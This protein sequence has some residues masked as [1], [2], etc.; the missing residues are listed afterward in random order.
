MVILNLING[1]AITDIQVRVNTS[2]YKYLI[3][4]IFLETKT[5]C[6]IFNFQKENNILH[7]LRKSFSLSLLELEVKYLIEQKICTSII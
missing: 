5:G 7:G 4:I 3:T 2:N 6:K 1:L